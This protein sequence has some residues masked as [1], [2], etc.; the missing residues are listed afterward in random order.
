[1]RCAG[2]RSVKLSQ[3][4]RTK[5][6]RLIEWS[7]ETSKFLDWKKWFKSEMN[8]GIFLDSFYK[9]LNRVNLLKPNYPSHDFFPWV[10]L[11]WIDQNEEFG[12]DLEG[13]E[14]ELLLSENPH[15]D[16]WWP[17][18]TETTPGSSLSFFL[19]IAGPAEH[20]APGLHPE[21]TEDLQRWDL[22]RR[23]T[24]LLDATLAAT[25]FLDPSQVLTL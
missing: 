2:A 17:T 7:T 15:N 18:N 6:P 10:V 3:D 21:L 1:M 5:A 12:Q 19:L 16:T 22:H 14:T 8:T 13:S 9:G 24:A 20:S 4:F 23:P 25:G 11:C